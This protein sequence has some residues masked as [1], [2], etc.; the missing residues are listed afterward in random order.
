MEVY[1][2]SPDATAKSIGLARVTSWHDNRC[3]CPNSTFAALT[4]CMSELAP[5]STAYMYTNKTGGLSSQANK[6]YHA[7]TYSAVIDT[8]LACAMQLQPAHG[9]VGCCAMQCSCVCNVTIELVRVWPCRF[10]PC[11]KRSRHCQTQRLCHEHTRPLVGYT[12]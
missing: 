9:C 2:S 3:W 4:A 1:R 5:T 12:L 6:C 8:A 11:N 7:G 10:R